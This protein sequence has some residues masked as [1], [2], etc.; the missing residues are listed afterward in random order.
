VAKVRGFL[1]EYNKPN[2]SSTVLKYQPTT[3]LS[4]V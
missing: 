3:L 1:K 4:V 2:K